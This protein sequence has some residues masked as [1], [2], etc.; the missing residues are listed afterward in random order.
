MTLLNP[1][2]T[3][4]SLLLILDV[5]NERSKS[6]S[7]EQKTETGSHGTGQQDKDQVKHATQANARKTADSK[8]STRKTE[9]KTR[10]KI[11]KQLSGCSFLSCLFQLS[12]QVE[13]S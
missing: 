8:T 7:Q 13:K 5:L 1:L 2:I 3:L 4:L 6:G 9:A 11:G 12:L 10:R